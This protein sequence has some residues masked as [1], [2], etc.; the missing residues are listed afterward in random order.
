MLSRSAGKVEET[1]T[2]LLEKLRVE[3]RDAEKSKR[4]REAET[5]DLRK[6]L[7]SKEFTVEEQVPPSWLTL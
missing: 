4:E 3:N 2:G 1:Q 7:N 5:L 6:K